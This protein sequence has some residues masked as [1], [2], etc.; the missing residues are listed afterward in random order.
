MAEVIIPLCENNRGSCAL[1]N[2]KDFLC[3]SRLELCFFKE[4]LVSKS[5]FSVTGISVEHYCL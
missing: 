4:M 2:N 3:C 1:K 5:Q